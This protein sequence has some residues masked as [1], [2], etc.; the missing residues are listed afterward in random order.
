MVMLY[1]LAIFLHYFDNIIKKYE[2]MKSVTA[3]TA[4]ISLSEHSG[5]CTLDI[6]RCA[7]LGERMSRGVAEYYRL[8]ATS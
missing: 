5:R 8:T 2:A 6:L 4:Y 3:T 1:R 7:T